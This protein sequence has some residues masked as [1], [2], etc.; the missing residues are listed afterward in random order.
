MTNKKQLLENNYSTIW[1]E[2]LELEIQRSC[3]AVQIIW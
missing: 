2:F 1:R 3:D